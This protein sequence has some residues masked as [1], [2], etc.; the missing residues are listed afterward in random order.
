MNIL[1]VLILEFSLEMR[2]SWNGT[3]FYVEF[4]VEVADHMFFIR[5]IIKE[6][7][8]KIS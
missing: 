8:I 7:Y 5:P 6:A 2:H 3:G 4:M 1:T